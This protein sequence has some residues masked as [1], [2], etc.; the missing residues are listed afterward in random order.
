VEPGEFVNRPSGDERLI[1]DPDLART[2]VGEV[3]DV[4]SAA[5][6]ERGFVR[7]PIRHDAQGTS[8]ALVAEIPSV[9]WV[10][11]PE[12]DETT[13]VGERTARVRM[14]PE[15]DFKVGD[16]LACQDHGQA[17]TSRLVQD[18]HALGGQG[19]R[20]LVDHDRHAREAGRILISVL[21]PDIRLKIT[22][23]H[24]RDAAGR[25]LPDQRSEEEV[26]DEA[27]GIH[28]LPA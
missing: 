23:R 26:D 28:L 7:F 8:P 9:F 11:G 24:A 20:D 12:R 2:P 18:V 10:R 3:V 15:R 1:P 22:E 19:V 16:R 5:G 13:D 25:V 4:R 14:A 6:E 21:P 17:G 27:V